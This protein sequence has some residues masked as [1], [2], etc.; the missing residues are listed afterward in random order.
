MSKNRV[1]IKA[2]LADQSGDIIPCSELVP[3][4]LRRVLSKAIAYRERI[5]FSSK[6]AFEGE[7]RR[8]AETI[9]SE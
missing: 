6:R 7:P 4:I 8:A 1:I 9:R 3:R 5:Y 2:V